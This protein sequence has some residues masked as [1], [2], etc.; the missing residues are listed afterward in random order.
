MTQPAQ[1]TGTRATSNWTLSRFL[2]LIACILFIIAALMAG[3]VIFKGSDFI[4]WALG[5]AAAWSLS[6]VGL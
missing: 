1:N 4:P 6:W 5:G 3:N 2:M